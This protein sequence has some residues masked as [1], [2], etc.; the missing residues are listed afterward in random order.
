MV[1]DVQQD[2]HGHVPQAG[3]LQLRGVA[4]VEESLPL[5]AQVGVVQRLQDTPQVPAQTVI[6]TF[7]GDRQGV[8][9]LLQAVVSA[10]R[11]RKALKEHSTIFTTS[12]YS[13]RFVSKTSSLCDGCS[14]ETSI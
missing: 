7:P 9:Q 3:A 1:G 10:G 5:G 13:S 8:Q 6:Q 2:E 12:L 4:G 11:H 14:L